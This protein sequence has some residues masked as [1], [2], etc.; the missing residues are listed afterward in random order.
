MRRNLQPA[1]SLRPGSGDRPPGMLGYDGHMMCLLIAIRGAVRSRGAALGG[2]M[3]LLKFM[4]W[5][6]GFR[7]PLWQM[8]KYILRVNEG[9]I[10]LTA[11]NLRV[12][13]VRQI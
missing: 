8:S 3:T 5:Y 7:I 9:M 11:A 6:V 12:S 13:N 10:M 2:Q 1:L 4:D